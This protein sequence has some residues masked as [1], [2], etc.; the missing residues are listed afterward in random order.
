[1][2]EEKAAKKAGDNKEQLHI[3][4]IGLDLDGTVYNEAKEITPGVRKAIEDAIAQGVIVLPATGRPVGGLPEAFLQIPGVR[5]ALTSNGAAVVDLSEKKRIYEDCIDKET[6]AQVISVM[7]KFQGLAETYMDGKCYTDKGNYENASNFSMVP[8]GL[9]AYIKSTRIPKEHLADYIRSQEHPV[10]KLHMIFGDTDTRD[11]AFAYIKKCFPDLTITNA[12]SFNMEINSPTCNK[13][14]ALLALGRILG[15]QP[16][17][18]MACGD[19]GNDYPMICAAGFSVAMGNAEERI[20]EA[21]DFVTKTNEEDGVAWAI[22]RF[23]LRPS[24]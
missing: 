5:Y 4:M 13:G 10:E 7:L 24:L 18:I 16:S 2:D 12:S 1:M 3:R 22:R 17:Q 11:K 21:A 14:T 15:I 6:A 19:S 23:V 8:P 9:L 20:K